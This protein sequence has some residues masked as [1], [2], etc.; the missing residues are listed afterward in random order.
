MSSRAHSSKSSALACGP[1]VCE[2]DAERAAGTDETLRNVYGR[3]VELRAGRT[4][5]LVF[6]HARKDETKNVPVAQAP[7]AVGDSSVIRFNA[8]IFSPPAGT[9]SGTDRAG[10]QGE[11]RELHVAPAP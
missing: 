3:L 4:F 5:Q 11:S 10:T 9:G 8:A 1:L 7:D 6:H 2:A